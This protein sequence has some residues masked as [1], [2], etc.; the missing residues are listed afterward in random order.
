[1]VARLVSSLHYN[2][3][4]ISSHVSFVPEPPISP[5]ALDLCGDKAGPGVYTG[6][7]VLSR[8]RGFIDA[9]NISEFLW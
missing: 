6:I 5:R 9:G 4:N 7:N 3:D 1:M 2:S 8:I